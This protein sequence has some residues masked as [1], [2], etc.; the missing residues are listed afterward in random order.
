MHIYIRQSV[1]SYSIDGDREYRLEQ[2]NK[3]A[4]KW[5]SDTKHMEKKN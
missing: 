1:Y 2:S 4:S 5:L 3:H